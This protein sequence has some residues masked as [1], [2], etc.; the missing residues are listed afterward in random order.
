[1]ANE[2]CHI[3]VHAVLKSLPLTPS[4]QVHRKVAL[5]HSGVTGAKKKKREEKK[6]LKD[7]KESERKNVA[8]SGKMEKGKS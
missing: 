4:L 8:R 5:F 6:Q 7:T 3:L 1:M 2:S